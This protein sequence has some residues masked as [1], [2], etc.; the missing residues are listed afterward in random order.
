MEEFAPLI[1]TPSKLTIYDQ[2]GRIIVKEGEI[3]TPAV[4]SAAR[5]SGRLDELRMAAAMA[6]EEPGRI[7]EATEFEEIGIEEPR[8]IHPE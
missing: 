8:G 1:G 4:I 5:D 7:I 2:E 3:I 6:S